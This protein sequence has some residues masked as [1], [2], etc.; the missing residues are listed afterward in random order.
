[1]I[2]SKKNKIICFA[3]SI[4][5]CCNL[6]TCLFIVIKSAA[7]RTPLLSEPQIKYSVASHYCNIF[8]LV[9]ATG[10]TALLYCVFY[11]VSVCECCFFFSIAQCGSVCKDCSVSLYINV[12]FGCIQNIVLPN[13]NA[14]V[15]VVLRLESPEHVLESGVP[16]TVSYCYLVILPLILAVPGLWYQDSGLSFLYHIATQQPGAYLALLCPDDFMRT[17]VLAVPYFYPKILLFILSVPRLLFWDSRL[18]LLGHCATPQFCSLSLL[19]P[20]CCTLIVFCGSY[21]PVQ[22]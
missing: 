11:Y 7:L 21:L 20:N 8:T 19:C 18:S 5:L 17:L 13:P 4:R 12:V 10:V 14:G 15:V 6:Y 16:L 1:M 9:T 3:F 22:H 2:R